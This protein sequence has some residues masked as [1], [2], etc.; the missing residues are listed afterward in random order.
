[1][2]GDI[3]NFNNNKQLNQYVRPLA[4]TIT[5]SYTTP[6]FHADGLAMKALSQAARDWQFGAVLRYQSGA[7][8]GDPTSLNNLTNQMARGATAFGA[9]ASN[10]QNYNGKPYFSISDPNC[11]CFNPQSAQVLNPA[12]WTDAPGGT[13]GSSAPFLGYRWQRQPAESAS[14][15][16]N[17]RIGKEGRY[18]LQVRG[19]FQNI[20]N[21][22]FLSA[23]SL[24]NPLLPIGTT[25]YNGSLL[26]AS[27]FGSIATLNGAGS[28]PRSGQLIARFSF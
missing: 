26:N 2:T 24:A 11:N 18:N 17:F 4:M 6:K 13:W 28:Q 1:V 5:F 12:A 23:P 8:L 22:T 25:T 14:F 9:G 10:F 7:L 27:G 16:R 21:R 20:F 3:Y 15:A 19:E